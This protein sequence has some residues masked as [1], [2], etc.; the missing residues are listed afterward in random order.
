MILKEVGAVGGVIS[1]VKGVT[2]KTL[3][4][5]HAPSAR[6]MVQLLWVDSERALKLI[7]LFQARPPEAELEQSPPYISVPVSVPLKVYS[8]VVSFVGFTTGVTSQRVGEVVSYFLVRVFET[9]LV[10]PAAS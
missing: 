9:V 6:V 7:V 2:F 8:G 10:L 5:F 1:I 4:T 3:E